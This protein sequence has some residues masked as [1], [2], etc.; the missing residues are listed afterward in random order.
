[1]RALQVTGHGE[2]AEVLAV[3]EVDVPQPGDGEVQI[4]VAT[5][6]LNFNDI[7]RCRGG[8]VSVPQ[9]PPF[10]LGMEV[11]GTVTAAGSGAEAWVGR[12]VV[13]VSKDAFGGLAEV[14]TAP[15]AGVFEAPPTLDDVAAAAFLLPFHTTWLALATRARLTSGETLLVHAGASGLG[16]AAIQL[17]VALGARVIAT[18]SSPEKAEVARAL[19]AE[20]VVDH[21]REDFVEAVLG[22]TDDVGAQVVCDLAG[23]EFVGKSWQCVAREGRYVPVGFTD[24]DQNGMTGRPL[25]LASIGNFSIVGVLGAF[26][27]VV[28]PGLRRFGFNPFTRA[29]GDQVHAG[30][31]DLLSSGRITPYVGSVVDLD[32]AAEA[33]VAHQERR[34][35]GR[36]VVRVGAGT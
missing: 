36:T 24:D 6:A 28:D 15:L 20:L 1:M 30:L 11:C 18:V 27:D 21:T 13:A 12:R 29:E 2:P 23:G 34:A 31:L 9:N 8:L 32:G 26:V 5:G 25:R 4:R 7:L 16:T 14:T 35:I 3:R 22:A 10:T 17:G 19:G 33:L